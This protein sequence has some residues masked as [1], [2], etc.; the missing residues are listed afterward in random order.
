[1]QS[2]AQR[3]AAVRPD[4]MR[5]GRVGHPCGLR[6]GDPDQMQRALSEP[7]AT[8]TGTSPSAPVLSNQPMKG[9]GLI[10]LAFICFTG[11]DTAGKY[12]IVTGQLPIAE[13]VWVR[14]LGQFLAIIIAL[15][16]F[17]VPSLLQ[18]RKPGWQLLRS[19]F[20]LISTL[21][22][23]LALRT[24]RLDQVMTIQFL[25]PLIVALLAGPLLGE[26]IGWRRMLAILVGFA[27][28]IVAVRPDA[29]SFEPAFL[30]ALSSMLAYASFSLSTRYLAPFDGVPVTLFYSMFAGV[31]LVAPFAL[32][33]W[34]WPATT[35]TWIAM[36]TCGVWA[37]IG[38]ALFIA[39]FRYAPASTLMPFT[40]LGL[41]THSSAGY[42][43][44]SQT[45]DAQTLAGAVIVVASG[46][47][48]LHREHVR[49]RPRHQ[50]E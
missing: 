29:G 16:L 39:A 5:G 36:I 6:S 33:E 15:G 28:V 22:N 9:I 1:M 44:F 35:G 7:N 10:C 4:G 41:L 37:A 30:L 31:A 27:G 46:L 42:L 49:Q 2:S 3:G 50:A 25:T 26:W 34:V 14:F 11:N 8:G 20:L 12:M 48:L 38:H 45:P 13:V 32:S 18:A 23:F 24:L 19:C 40:Y 47:Y 17:A 43:V 21:F